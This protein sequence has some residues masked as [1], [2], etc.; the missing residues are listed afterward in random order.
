MEAHFDPGVFNPALL[1]PTAVGRPAQGRSKIEDY[2]KN[3]LQICI[4]LIQKTMCCII[5]QS[6]HQ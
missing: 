1:N 2:S 5:A 6:L 3:K 4:C